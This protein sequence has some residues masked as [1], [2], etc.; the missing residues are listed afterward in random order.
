M[1]NFLFF[2]PLKKSVIKT[3][4]RSRILVRGQ[5]S[6]GPRGGALSS[7]FAQ[8]RG[9]PLKLPENCMILKKSWMQGGG[10][11]GPKAPLDPLLCSS[12]SIITTRQ[13]Q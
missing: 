8:N 9:F 7:K 11:S 3:R 2:G 12:R 13:P 10:G 4:R 6:F 5:R 1:V